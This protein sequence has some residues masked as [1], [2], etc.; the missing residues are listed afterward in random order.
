MHRTGK[1]CFAAAR[2]RGRWLGG[3]GKR[4]ATNAPTRWHC[5]YNAAMTNEN[6]SLAI[7]FADVNGS[8]RL[9]ETLGDKEALE[10]IDRCLSILSTL[11]RKHGGE[12]VKT[13]GDEIMCAFPDA[14]SAF[15]A[16][17]AMQMEMAMQLISGKLPLY[18]HIGMHYGPAIRDDGDVFGDAVNIAARLTKIAKAGQIITSQQTADNLPAELRTDIRKLGNATLRGKREEMDICE[19][20]WQEAGDLTLMP[21]TAFKTAPYA[22]CLVLRHAGMRLAIDE[23]KPAAVLG[24]DKNNDLV[25]NAPLA[26]RQHAQIEYRGGKFILI[27]QSTNGTYV[28]T[29]DGRKS[30]VHRE[31]F[32]L[33]GSGSISL[34][35]DTEGDATSPLAVLFACE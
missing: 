30:F 14:E 13:I 2:Y 33:S 11:S 31:E 32:P 4:Q 34:G 10:R 3:R 16:A 25:V 9:Y 7:L 5:R 15:R 12:T 23:K 22:G 28:Y 6:V 35:S 19:I 27:D 26:S 29:E 1:D 18:I 21:G 20:I 17:R 24:R 8:T